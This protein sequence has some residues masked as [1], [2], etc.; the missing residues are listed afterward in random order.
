MNEVEKAYDDFDI[1]N[2]RKAKASIVAG[3]GIY[4][5]SL[6]LVFTY[7]V[8]F[9]WAIVKRT[10]CST[11]FERSHYDS[12]ISMFILSVI[13]NVVGFGMLIWGYMLDSNGNPSPNLMLIFS[14]F[15]I[16]GA[17]YVWNIIRMLK[18]LSLASDLK[19]Y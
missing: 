15:A 8:A 14:G 12:M 18:G 19:S 5:L 10:N 9:V 3:W 16:M 13:F 2:K 7:F 1:E 17:T 6:F 4:L 11:D